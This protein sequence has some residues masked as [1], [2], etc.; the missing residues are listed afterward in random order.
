M[1]M[2]RLA[3]VLIFLCP[4]FGMADF[5]AG[6]PQ[7]ALKTFFEALAANDVEKIKD[8]F[9]AGNEQERQ[10]ANAFAAQIASAK[11][12]GEAL[13]SKFNSGGDALTRGMPVREQLARLETAQV[14]IEGE[15]ATIQLAQ[16][17]RPLHLSRVE[18]RWRISVS[19]F[20]GV[21]PQT[22]ASHIA[23]QR[24]L[25]AA[26]DA[27]TADVLA[28]KFATPQDAQRALQQKMQA[29]LFDTLKKNPPATTRASTR[30][31]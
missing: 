21:T 6:S 15:S 2:M 13:K 17:A 4:T 30:S 7:A 12:L 10:L 27:F 9:H 19:D 1:P 26:F 23:V 31:N 20:A 29:V 16:S 5:D 3:L 11:K 22:A 14:K 8:A 18:G 24:D 28:D 25:A